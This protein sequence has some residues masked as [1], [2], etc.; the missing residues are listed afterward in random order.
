MPKII[1]LDAETVGK[2]AA[3]EVVERPASAIK[4]LMENAVD[5]GASSI[6][7]EIQG[8]GIAALRVTDNGCGIA[9]QDVRMAFERHATSKIR[10]VEDLE[11][12]H[13]MGFRGE[14]LHAIAAVTQ[15][16]LTTRT[17][18]QAMGVRVV[19]HGGQIVEM[20]DAG[21]AEGTSVWARNLF[22]NTPARLKFLKKPAQEGA[23]VSDMVMR[24]ILANPHIA[25]QYR[26]DGKR[27][28][29]SSGDGQFQSALAAV[30][31]REIIDQLVPISAQSGTFSLE[32][33]VGVGE[34][35]RGNRAHQT[36]FVNGR[37]VKHPMLSYGLEDAC[38]A[39]VMIG[40]FPFCVLRLT[41]HPADVDVNAHPNK[42]EVRFRDERFV[43]GVVEDLVERALLMDDVRR[44]QPLAPEKEP[45][46]M[47][48][49]PVAL[50]NAV[51]E[52]AQAPG[53]APQAPGADDEQGA[54][55]EVDWRNPAAP[56]FRAQSGSDAQKPKA[57]AVR[58]PL[59]TGAITWPDVTKRAAAAFAQWQTPQMPRFEAKTLVPPIEKPKGKDEAVQA[60]LVK[61]V[62]DQLVTPL[63]HMRV[64]GTA[65]ATYV[66]VEVGEELLWID[67]HAAHERILYEKY[68]A[69]FGRV[70]SQ[71]LLLAQTVLVS[72]Q[73]RE[74]LERERQ[75]FEEGGFAFEWLGPSELGITAVPVFLG[76]AEVGSAILEMLDGLMGTHEPLSM[77]QRQQ[78]IAKMACH[79]AIR[80]GDTLTNDEIR[81][82]IDDLRAGK[83]T[84]CPHGRPIMLTDTRA[85]IERRFGRLQ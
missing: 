13:T 70:A 25:F 67:Q 47:L 50:P 12:I 71:P 29:R 53:I 22:Y 15:L 20:T 33:F 5:S 83:F 31:G 38:R 35:A 55:G 40:K 36:F 17:K 9:P 27:I 63:E 78:T 23:L 59:G 84:H 1:R 2:I 28:Y 10:K 65:F 14:A 72:H 56:L 73:E 44:I 58:E 21:C 16:E 52:K 32:G 57:D 54:G 8:G 46:K 19:N 51:T 39:R 80:G 82:L 26:V 34:A 30:Y 4:E 18:D 43:R 69:Q 7:V 42:I 3:G 11:S 61:P 79:A 75:V 85:Q 37:Y 62:Q 49:E 60:V 41:M 74:V 24:L 77:T 64:I 81:G 66:L 76:N 48:D 45:E 68:L 6:S